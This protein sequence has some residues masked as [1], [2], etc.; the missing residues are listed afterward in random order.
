MCCVTLGGMQRLGDQWWALC[1]GK[2]KTEK[3][4]TPTTSV[5]LLEDKIRSFGHLES[6]IGKCKSGML[7]LWV[8]GH[9]ECLC[10]NYNRKE[11]IPRSA[12]DNSLP[13]LTWSWSSLTGTRKDSVPQVLLPEEEKLII[14]ET[15]SNGQTIIEEKSLVDTVYALKDEVKEL[16]QENKKMKQ[17]LEEELK[18]RKDLEKLVRKLLK[19]TDECIRSESSSKTSILQ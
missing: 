7:A 17:C 11:Q 1:S 6:P 3:S 9:E 18:S 16:K 8:Q 13:H 15:R 10:C 12:S 2:G 4:G 14:E 5:P 19:Q